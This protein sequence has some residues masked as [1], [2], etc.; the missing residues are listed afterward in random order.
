MKALQNSS[1]FG[2]FI[3]LTVS[4]LSCRKQA[5][6]PAPTVAL[7]Q[8]IR[9]DS[10]LI[11]NGYAITVGQIHRLE[12]GTAVQTAV[13][14]R[15]AVTLDNGAFA[16]LD[17]NTDLAIELN[18]L[19][20]NRG[21][22]WIDTSKASAT[23][24][25]AP[26]GELS[27]EGAGFAVELDRKKKLSVYCGA[28]ELTF[29]SN[30]GNGRLRQGETLIFFDAA[31]PKV[32]PEALWH[33]WTGGLAVPRVRTTLPVSQIGMLAGRVRE[34]HGTARLPLPI[35]SHEV[36]VKIQNDLAVT[37]VVQAFFNARSEHLEAEYRIRLPIAA[38]VAEFA[39]DTG[40]GF[41]QARVV[42][43]GI[44]DR[45]E[46]IWDDNPARHGSVLTYESAERLRAR[47]FPVD[48]GATIRVKLR[49]T[50]WLQRRGDTRTYVYPMGAEG[51]SPLLS[52][53]T[54][55]V[56]TSADSAGAY[57]AGMG[58][59]VK[60]RTIVLRHSDFT[61]RADFYLDLIDKKDKKSASTANT[62]LAEGDPTAKEQSDQARYAFFNLA[63]RA[64]TRSNPADD[65]PLALVILVDRSGSTEPENL[66]LAQATV[67]SLLHQ[68]SDKD[69]VAIRIADIDAHVPE[70]FI[71]EGKA[72]G[73]LP[74][75]EKTRDRI[76]RSL[77]DVDQGGATDLGASLRTA[78]ACL[79]DQPRG[80]VIYLGD[81][82]PTTGALDASAIKRDLESLDKPPRF[83]G[84]AIGDQAN[85][86]LLQALFGTRARKVCERTEA[87]RAVMH[88]L[89]DASGASL[90]DLHVDLGPQLERVYPKVPIRLNEG[91]PLRLVG[92]LMGQLPQH[93]RV[94]GNRD[95]KAFE[96]TIQI[97]SATIQDQGDLQRRWGAARL[98]ELLDEN[99][100]PEALIELGVR[101]GLL[102][103]WTPFM[104]GADT[105]SKYGLV[106][107]FDRDPLEIARQ[108]AGGG[109]Q[110]SAE[111]LRAER[112][113]WR[114]RVSKP[115]D[116][117]ASIPQST[118]TKRRST[119]AVETASQSSGLARLAVRNTLRTHR[120]GPQG[121]YER[122]ARI[123]PDLAGNLDVRVKVD[124][125]GAVQEAKLV[126]SNL[127]ASRVE[128]CLIQ[129]IKGLPFPATGS[130]KAIEFNHSYHFEISQTAIGERRRCSDASAQPLDIRRELWQERL[131]DKPGVN[132]AL[133]VWRIAQRTCELPNWRAR[134]TLLRKILGSVGGLRAQVRI[135]QAFESYPELAGYLRRAI[136]R[137]VRTAE[138]VSVVRAGLALDMD[139]QWQVFLRIWKS[140]P[141]PRDRLLLVRR[142]LSVVPDDMDLRVR[143][144]NLLEETGAVA[145]AKRHARKLRADPMADAEV[146]TQLGE[147]WL[148][149]GDKKEAY[150]S[151][152]E[153]VE[154]AP[155][156]PWARRRLGDLYRAH[157][158]YGDAY[159]EYLILN[160]LRPN[161]DSVLL[162]LA[163]AAAGAGRIDE[164]LRLE[165]RVSES[166]ESAVAHPGLHP[167]RQQTGLPTWARLWTTVRLKELRLKAQGSEQKLFAIGRRERSTGVLRDPP[168]VFA[169]ITWNHP[170][171]LP[172]LF[173]RTP[174]EK[175]KD[176]QRAEMQGGV[177]GVEAVSLQERPWR[178]YLLEVRRIES[179][180][181]RPVKAELW[182]A[183]EVGTKNERV[184][185]KSIELTKEK[186]IRRYELAQDGILAE[187]PVTKI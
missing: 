83:Y 7:L 104:V 145:E 130:T 183:T 138:D 132:G 21:R 150:R 12:K 68:L 29:R 125:Q 65:P 147:F 6:P 95:G 178:K 139:V 144:L 30:K 34:Q 32:R 74:A 28:G 71:N 184:T 50:E 163:R 89:Q 110:P 19:T 56:D 161:D 46:P 23:K 49:Y 128:S 73:F 38:I 127:S 54:L 140:Q 146:R 41:Q 70:P 131:E 67:A 170:D 126:A 45:G 40:N 78:A 42:E 151:F 166:V 99:A 9:G 59:E 57:R 13:D 111:Q 120:R 182:V 122:E 77:A 82:K 1:R 103:P 10:K 97:R 52:E 135:Y 115:I 62:Y 18:T 149:Q 106:K 118:W 107:R 3:L 87:A 88:I 20:L 35:R 96:E 114:R 159:R 84:L 43:V 92:R 164:A 157:G 25:F 2:L 124:G 172:Q 165:Q 48:P 168:A 72:E 134:R 91:E 27:A 64:D 100:G 121:C 15:A 171:D 143:R 180:A 75:D 86:S 17:H 154:Y 173:I 33:D 101:F 51:S 133:S 14:S 76:M 39:V 105:K 53:F 55:Q 116:Q 98:A 61:P 155:L 37:E 160:R 24:L 156:D 102:T 31:P 94:T 44:N 90:T 175:D 11:R 113:G 129:E 80:A 36:K 66:E 176:W 141:D 108:L 152:S 137:N 185:K 174:Q 60:G 167:S 58:A 5:P 162:S 177:H 187:R 169:A 79:A 47:I 148:R 181:I 136:M 69:Q 8:P 4:C 117:P 16:L 153:I 93:V 179:D 112:S 81:A 26:G 109:S 85:H 123:R 119:S 142:W 22:V 186:P 158:W 63:L